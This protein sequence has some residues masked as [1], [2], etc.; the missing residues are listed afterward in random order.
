MSS[1]AP[2]YDIT[3]AISS[4]NWTQCRSPLTLTGPPRRGL[5]YSYLAIF[6]QCGSTWLRQ[7]QII[8]EA[9]RRS[10]KAMNKHKQGLDV[11]PSAV[12]VG[13]FKPE[14]YLNRAETYLLLGKKKRAI[15]ALD[16]GLRVDSGDQKLLKARGEFGRRKPRVISTLPRGHL[17][18]R[19]LGRLR[20]LAWMKIARG[21][22]SQTLDQRRS[23]AALPSIR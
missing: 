1:S 12:E 17:V 7:D 4:V 8:S 23:P 22:Q 9:D 5:V 18:N 3:A 6:R 15:A 11:C 13:G 16:R 10:G 21:A 14:P 20:R 2:N 19:V